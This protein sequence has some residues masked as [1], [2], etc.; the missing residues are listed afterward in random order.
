MFVPAFI[1]HTVKKRLGLSSEFVPQVQNIVDQHHYEAK[2]PTKVR[3][4]ETPVHEATK[5]VSVT[6]EEWFKMAEADINERNLL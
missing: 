2:T 1:Q 6:L 5:A 3:F 4:Q